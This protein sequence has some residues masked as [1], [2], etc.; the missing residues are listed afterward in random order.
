M[1][2]SSS[3][4]AVLNNSGKADSSH[5]GGA[6]TSKVATPSASMGLVGPPDRAAPVIPVFANA[7][8]LSCAAGTCVADLAAVVAVAEIEPVAVAETF[9]GRIGGSL[10]CGL[11]PALV[12]FAAVARGI[13]GVVT[14]ADALGWVVGSIGADFA[15]ADTG[16]VAGADLAVGGVDWVVGAGL[17]AGVGAGLTTAGVDLAGASGAGLARTVVAV[18]GVMVG[19]ADV[20]AVVG[21]TWGWAFSVGRGCWLALLGGRVG[22]GPFD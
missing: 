14:A 11:P 21:C 1:I 12:G 6:G 13:G 16:V 4:Q 22:W 17:D 18:P 8:T 19:A 5:L 9:A 15:F 3:F 10:A 2:G 20:V 7:V